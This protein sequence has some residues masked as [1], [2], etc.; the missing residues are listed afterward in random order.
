MCPL[1]LHVRAYFSNQVSLGKKAD[2]IDWR[3]LAV[4]FAVTLWAGLVVSQCS[5]CSVVHYCKCPTGHVLTVV[6]CCLCLMSCLLSSFKCHVC[7]SLQRW[8]PTMACLGQGHE[9]TIT[10]TPWNLTVIG[11]QEKISSIGHKKVGCPVRVQEP[12]CYGM[13]RVGGT[14]TTFI[15]AQKFL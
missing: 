3:T 9:G 11:R 15:K 7:T 6:W 5:R 12:R 14:G 13:T 10:P 4:G 2:D 8:R 1:L